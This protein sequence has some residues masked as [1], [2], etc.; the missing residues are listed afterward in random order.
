MSS[1]IVASTSAT[2]SPSSTT[3]NVGRSDKGDVDREKT[4]GAAS[5][6]RRG[7]NSAS[8]DA[9]SGGTDTIV[10]HCD[11][12]SLIGCNDNQQQKEEGPTQKSPPK[13]CSKKT[14]EVGNEYDPKRLSLSS[15]LLEES[16]DSATSRK[17]FGEGP[18][19]R[20][21]RRIIM[22]VAKTGKCS[23]LSWSQETTTLANKRK[24]VEARAST[25][26]NCS[27]MVQTS[28]AASSKSQSLTKAASSSSPSSQYSHSFAN[29]GTSGGIVRKQSSF[30]GGTALARRSTGLPPRKRHRNGIVHKGGE[31]MRFGNADGAFGRNNASSNSRKRPLVSV[32]TNSTSGSTN[33]SSNI[34]NT[35][36]TSG[37]SKMHNNTP[38]S[39]GGLYSSAP[40]S[41]GSGRSTGSEPEYDSAQY[42]CDS[43]GTSATTNSEISARKS[44]R[45]KRSGATNTQGAQINSGL[46]T[47]TDTATVCDGEDENNSVDGSNAIPGSPYKTLQTAFR[48]ALG[49]VLDHF[50]Q[51]SSNGYKLSPAEK[52][53]N[54][55]LAETLNRNSNNNSISANEFDA[56]MKSD[57]MSSLLS[58]EYVF[59]RRRQRLMA[60]LLP[61]ISQGGQERN[62]EEPPFTIQRIAEVLVAPDRVS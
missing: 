17:G 34:T 16:N 6:E 26:S 62:S 49:L 13:I 41:V 39:M 54:E 8:V 22:E 35:A 31:R 57:K 18:L 33:S 30:A 60:M 19:P 50:Y 24:S 51:N 5:G 55:R 28:A 12:T 11:T 23:W 56:T 58:S 7:N 52:K 3:A 21:L 48:G 38:N 27:R 37:S 29:A 46:D 14:I 47:W 61:T 10:R 9:E 15:S 32:R 59:Q 42:E 44:T 36:L 40:S 2:T 20:E 53:R 45:A 4:D 1:A 43:E 25:N